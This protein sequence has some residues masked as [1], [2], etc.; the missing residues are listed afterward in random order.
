MPLM[1]FAR[2]F[3]S[4]VGSSR[5]RS[6]PRDWSR[7]TITDRSGCLSFRGRSVSPPVC[8]PAWARRADLD[9]SWEAWKRREDFREDFSER[10]ALERVV[11]SVKSLFLLSF[12]DDDIVGFEVFL[13]GI[14]LDLDV[15]MSAARSDRS[16]AVVGI[17]WEI[18]EGILVV[19]GGGCR[20]QDQVLLVS[21]VQ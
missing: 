7:L 13:V 15:G 17:G 21:G 12:V 2:D 3:S 18:L 14:D 20:G 16:V 4:A 11:G 1:D 6:S 9:R 19:V 5:S 8:L 10:S